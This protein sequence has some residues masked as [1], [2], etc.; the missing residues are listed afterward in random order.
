MLFFGTKYAKAIQSRIDH[1]GAALR[2]ATSVRVHSE[3]GSVAPDSLELPH[4]KLT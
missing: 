1:Q 2:G 3:K 4:G